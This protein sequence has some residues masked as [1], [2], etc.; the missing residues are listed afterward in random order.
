MLGTVVLIIIASIVVEGMTELLSKSLIFSPFVGWLVGFKGRNRILEFFGNAFKCGY[1]C[2][3]W[4]SILITCLVFIF[5]PQKI[6]GFIYLDIFV[7]MVVCHRLSNYIHNIQDRIY[8]NK[9]VERTDKH[10]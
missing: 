8:Y 2:S 9:A 1:C 3:N 5:S 6:F 4:M 7:F 10:T